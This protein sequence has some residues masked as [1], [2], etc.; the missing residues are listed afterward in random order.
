M[1]D[2]SD[3]EIGANSTAGAVANRD[4]EPDVGDDIQE[5]RTNATPNAAEAALQN[6][7]G[8]PMDPTETRPVLVPPKPDS[9]DEEK[10]YIKELEAKAN[11]EGIKLGQTWYV[12]ATKWW[13]AWKDYTSFDWYSSTEKDKTPPG[14]INNDA[15]LEQ[16]GEGKIK[17]TCME[18]YDFIIVSEEMWQTLHNW[19]GGG[20]ELARSVI[21]SGWSSSNLQ[22]EIRPLTLKVCKSSAIST[23]STVTFSKSET[24]GGFKTK[25]CQQMGLNPEDVRVWDYHAFNKYKLLEDMKAK[26]DSAQIIDGQ[27]MLLEEKD[28]NGKFPEIPKS[29]SMYS[30]Y[31]SHYNTGG[32]TEPG[33]CGLI[34]LGNTCFM[35]SSLQCLSNTAPLTDFFLT[36]RY[37]PDINRD[38]PLGM[39][40]EV[41]DEYADLVKELWSGT[42]SAVAPREFKWK[43]ERFAPQ[44]AGYQQH[45]S[46]ELLAFLL[47]GLHED[48]NRVKN[49]PYT[50]NPE[51]DGQPE[52]EVAREAWKR[53]KERNNSI[54]VDWFQ[55]Q[56]KSTLVCPECERVSITFDPSMYLSLPLPMKTTRVIPVTLF[57]LDPTKQPMKYACEVNKFGNVKDLQASLST[58]SGLS[59]ESIVITDVYNSRFFKQFGP[60]ESLDAIQDRDIICGYEILLNKSEDN[61]ISC[62]HVIHRKEERASHPYSIS[63]QKRSLFGLPFILSLPNASKITYKQLYDIIYSQIQRVFKLPSGRIVRTTADMVGEESPER[64]PMQS[65]SDEEAAPVNTEKDELQSDSSTDEDK[66]EKDEKLQTIQMKKKRKVQPLFTIKAVDN[67]GMNDK[68]ELAD[69]DKPL[70]FDNNQTLAICWSE[71][72]ADAY[73]DEQAAKDIALHESCNKPK[74]KELEDSITLGKCIDLF[75]TV[76]KLG[77]ED[78][79]FCSKCKQFQQ[80]TKKF[81]LWSLPPILVIHLKRFSYKNRYWREKLET[82]VNYPTKD[83]DLSAYVKGPEASK[84]VYDLYAVSNH[85]GSLGGG[86]YTAYAKNYKNGKWYKFDDSSVSEVEESRV[87]TSSAYVLFYRRKDTLDVANGQTPVTTTTTTTTSEELKDEATQM[88]EDVPTASPPVTMAVAGTDGPGADAE[89]DDVR[90]D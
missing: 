45:D 6:D 32:P 47:D 84:C 17:K 60:E 1:A 53:H 13:K 21:Q 26:L 75:T 78:P 48:L 29:K 37:K 90:L 30:S 67:Y 8:D 3:V 15:I 79:W 9:P 18:N 69:D 50:E 68:D 31:S 43:L 55:G 63:Y 42:H 51:V 87:V 73:Y 25:M 54:I 57:Y 10:Q 7:S 12:L 35:N 52:E 64:K 82:L 80:A 71:E 81:D 76:E 46:Q 24:V 33:T 5:E 4:D 14:P 34:N 28:E 66:T 77:P 40:G 11:L 62:F 70:E 39:K 49:K 19:Y 89:M 38:N 65:D 85:Y 22:V 72:I 23:F 58:F 61:D 74:E 56:L 16:G 36:D 86:H 83:L 59:A 44:F 2:T 27:P 41:A 20:P 88:E